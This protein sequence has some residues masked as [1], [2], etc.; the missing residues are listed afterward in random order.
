MKIKYWILF[1]L[2]LLT[3][4]QM[5]AKEAVISLQEI[6][7]HNNI[8]DCWIIINDNVY[9]ISQFIKDH[10]VL[11]SKMKL[12]D[13]CGKDASKIWLEKENSSYAHKFKSILKLK[14]SQIGTLRH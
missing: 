2:L 13:L 8:N 7:S 6:Q 4:Q 3:Y 5:F 11:C 1:F 10:N 14:R 9:D 12:S